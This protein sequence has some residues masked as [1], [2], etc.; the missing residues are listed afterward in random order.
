VKMRWTDLVK[1]C[2]TRRVRGR[3]SVP[4]ES[5][6]RHRDRVDKKFRYDAY[7]LDSQKHY[8]H[9]SASILDLKQIVDSRPR[10]IA[11]TLCSLARKLTDLNALTESSS[12][13]Y[14]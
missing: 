12:C 6:A 5:P 2:K 13:W 11:D 10:R 4:C 9:S 1:V 8:V 3:V 14:A 7:D